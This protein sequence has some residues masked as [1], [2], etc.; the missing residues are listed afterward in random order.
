MQSFYIAHSIFSIYSFFNSYYT[1]I[2]YARGHA[3]E[4][5]GN[6]TIALDVPQTTNTLFDSLLTAFGS[7]L[8]I[9]TGQPGLD[10]ALN[11]I[12]QA[13]AVLKFAFPVGSADSREVQWADVDA[14]LGE[15]ADNWEGNVTQALASIQEDVATFSAVAGG[16]AF[17]TSPVASIPALVDTSLVGLNTFVVS[18]SLQNNQ[19]QIARA[20]VEILSVADSQRDDGDSSTAGCTGY[21]S[22]SFCGSWWYDSGSNV[23]YSLTSYL[24]Q[25]KDP[26]DVFGI[27]E[28]YS[29]GPLLFSGAVQCAGG[30][31]SIN[32][33]GGAVT[34][35][36]LSNFKVCT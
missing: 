7:I 28:K 23:S 34:T 4:N 35:T 10:Q 20:D 19:W 25:G 29:T 9:T 36:C 13:T 1:A 12:V 15:V 26:S 6:I 14:A 5:V 8:T 16:G 27:L 21:D 22:G 2:E 18:Q 30:T 11:A 31:P 24:D 3:A 17:A 32:T 33:D